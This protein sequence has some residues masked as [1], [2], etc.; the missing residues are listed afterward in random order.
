MRKY[1]TNIFG[2][3]LINYYYLGVIMFKRFLLFSIIFSAANSFSCAACLKAIGNDFDTAFKKHYIVLPGSDALVEKIQPKLNSFIK[4]NKGKMAVAAV[5][6][7]LS[8]AFLFKVCGVDVSGSH[9]Q[10]YIT[11]RERWISGILEE[12]SGKIINV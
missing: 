12:S 3:K 8:L 6:V 5:T 7:P 10:S 11:A 9:V 1:G 4:K 2:G